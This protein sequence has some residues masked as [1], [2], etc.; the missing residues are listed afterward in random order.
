MTG[1]LPAAA[2]AAAALELAPDCEDSGGPCCCCSYCLRRYSG[3]DFGSYAPVESFVGSDAHD[4]NDASVLTLDTEHML[5]L[6]ERFGTGA[7]GYDI[8][9][10]TP[11]YG[12]EDV[13]CTSE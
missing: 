11:L 12:D 13:P 2:A 1:V 5:R 4:T 8:A 3:T 6:R 7:P 10:D 9:A